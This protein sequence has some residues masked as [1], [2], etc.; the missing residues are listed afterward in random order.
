MDRT[1]NKEIKKYLLIW[2]V[3]VAVILLELICFSV[4][5]ELLLCVGV[6]GIVCGSLLFGYDCIRKKKRKRE[7]TVAE[8]INEDLAKIQKGNYSALL[9]RTM[10]MEQ[11]DMPDSWKTTFETLNELGYYLEDMQ[12]RLR[13]EENNTKSLI[14][15][16]S[17]QLKTPLASLRMCHELTMTENLTEE[18]KNEFQEQE[19]Q[20]IEKLELLLNELVKLSRLENHMVQI[21]AEQ[22][23]IQQ[24]IAEAV[25]LVYG[26]AKGK[27][28]DIQVELL[29]N[30]S[31]LH[32]KKWTAQA[33][34]NVLDNAIKYSDNGSIIRVSVKLLITNVLIEIEDWGIG[35]L[36]EEI[37]NIFKRFYRGKEAT[38][39]VKDGVGV[40]L[41]LSRLIIELQGGTILAK[42]KQEK[43]T[44]FQITLPLS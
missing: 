44:I 21:Q 41:Y 34:A 5:K 17:H 6:T 3:T 31:I 10:D 8:W 42:R 29:A 7:E 38:R 23:N 2:L 16:I 15:D 1:G 14:T 36:P 12:E 32:D 35:I 4:H 40:G 20:E 13:E 19:K 39:K 37:H 9:S 27:Q 30:V 26:K 11:M 18:E 22:Q 33:L 28:I 24:T 25:S 43:G